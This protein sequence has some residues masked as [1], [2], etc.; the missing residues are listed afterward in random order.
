MDFFIYKITIDDKPE[1]IYV[2][3]TKNFKNRVHF[4][5]LSCNTT[6][7]RILYKTINENGG[8]GNCKMIL[9]DH[10]VGSK[11]DARI[12]ENYWFETLK[13]N[14]NMYKP[15]ITYEQKIENMKRYYENHKEEAK[16]KNK[17]YRQ[18][19]HETILEKTKEYYYANQE[20]YNAKSKEYRETH[21]EEM[22][23]Y[24]KEWHERNKER[25]HQKNN[26]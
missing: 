23:A 26:E 21:Q 12:K 10:I 5:K 2:G 20:Y 11:I 18:A 17:E 8:W 24:K 25:I 19:N 6:P 7:H 3:H 9:I 13:A 16:T 22:K 4:H 14:M 1:F 15:Y